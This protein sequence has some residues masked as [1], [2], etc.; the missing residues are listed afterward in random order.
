MA[1]WLAVM[2]A[3]VLLVVALAWLAIR[4]GFDVFTI[5]LVATSA[6]VATFLGSLAVRQTT[7][8]RRVI[9]LA[10]L[11]AWL[12]ISLPIMRLLAWPYVTFE[13][14]TLQCGHQPV[15][16]TNFAAGHRYTRAGDPDYGPSFLA[17]TYYCSPSDAEAAGYHRR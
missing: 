14:A 5:S 3:W 15:V 16:A 8:R 1:M 10:A 11:A 17:N 9:W 7:S 12:A 2:L 6:G 13:L 4:A